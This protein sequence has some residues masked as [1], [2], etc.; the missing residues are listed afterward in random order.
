M[1]NKL[2]G[3]AVLDDCELERVSDPSEPAEDRAWTLMKLVRRKLQLNPSWFVDICKIF[4]ACGI[5][6]ISQV[7]GTQLFP[8]AVTCN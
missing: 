4:R 8:P 2:Y 3:I 5:R 7:V 6:A 1:A